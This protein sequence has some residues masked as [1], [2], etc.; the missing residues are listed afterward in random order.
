[1]DK[2]SEWQV[3]ATGTKTQTTSLLSHFQTIKFSC[4]SALSLCTFID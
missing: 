2:A 1:M 3:A 4:L